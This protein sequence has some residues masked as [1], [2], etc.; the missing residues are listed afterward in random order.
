M[1][2]S[3]ALMIAIGSPLTNAL[4]IA[5]SVGSHRLSP[6][7]RLP[8]R[9]AV[10]CA[11]PVGGRVRAWR[12]GGGRSG[13]LP[14]APTS[15]GPRRAWPARRPAR[16]VSRS[17]SACWVLN[18]CCASRQRRHRASAGWLPRPRRPRS[19]FC[20]ASRAADSLFTCS[21]RARCRLVITCCALTDNVW[22]AAAVFE[23]VGGVARGQIRIRRTVDIRCGGEG[24]EALLGRGDGG[25]G[26]LDASL[27]GVDLLL[28][29]GGVVPRGLHVDDRLVDAFLLSLD[30][31]AE[32]LKLLIGVG[33]G[34]DQRCRG[35][36]GCATARPGVARQHADRQRNRADPHSR[37]AEARRE[38]LIRLRSPRAQR[39]RAGTFVGRLCD[40]SHIKHNCNNRHRFA[41]YV[42]SDAKETL[43]TNY[44]FVIECS[45]TEW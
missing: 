28:G 17:S 27:A 39:E 44:K 22:P 7:C 40:R 18:V 45:V 15:C 32:F 24:V 41:P 11:I 20:L 4:G 38:R 12:R 16:A 13:G 19:A 43:V 2:P 25:V 3:I 5:G 1:M 6:S 30:R 10:G 29:G 31:G 36:P 37:E 35:C 34:G 26:V 14:A 33:D 8:G 23:D 42:T 21:V 9:R